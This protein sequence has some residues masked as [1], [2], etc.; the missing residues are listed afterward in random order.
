MPRGDRKSQTVNIH[1]SGPREIGWDIGIIA[2]FFL[3]GVGGNGGGGG[4]QGGGGGAGA[5]PTVN[6][7]QHHG[8]KG[9]YSAFYSW[10]MT[11]PA[12]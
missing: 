3:G 7:I 10:M 1:I 4:I 5:A 2:Y 6:Y 11:D 9:E 8:E 12:S